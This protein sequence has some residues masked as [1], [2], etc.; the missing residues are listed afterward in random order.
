MR[1]MLCLALFALL[2]AMPVQAYAAEKVEISFLNFASSEEVPKVILKVID[3]FEKENPDIKIK[4]IPIGVGDIRNQLIVMIMGGNPPDV[5][6]LHV[7][8][9]AV[10]YS[11]GALLPSEDLYPASFTN[12]LFDQFYEEVRVGDKHSAILWSPNTMTFHYNKKIARQIG[13]DG[14]P[15]TIEEMEEMMKKAKEQIPDVIGFQVDTTIR[16]VGFSHIWNYMNMFEYEV[17]KGNTAKFNSENMVKFGEWIRRMVKLGYTLPGKRFGEFRPMA[18]QG[19]VLFSLDSAQHRGFFNLFNKYT[20]DDEYVKTWSPMPSPLGPSGRHIAT[21]DDHTLVVI[22]ST[23]HKEAVAKFVE[24]LVGSKSALNKYHGP[25]GFLPPVKD[26]ETLA[27]GM[28]DDQGRQGSMK[29]AV[30]YIVNLPSG[31]NYAKV[32]ILVMTG[33]Q[34]IITTDKPVKQ[35]LDSYQLKLEGVLQ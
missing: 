34:E 23:K 14:P 13:Y 33:I 3:D 5:A 22:K 21:P 24:Y 7:A 10:V 1:K 26:Y 29:Y 27:P 19:R 9:A 28:F 16:T 4:N 35:I 6:Q 12:R 8:D 30:P 31:P 32:A 15:K 20:N 17:I 18:A 25:V 2:C 11:M